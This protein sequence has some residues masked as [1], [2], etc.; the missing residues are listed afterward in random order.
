MTTTSTPP[1]SQPGPP[2]S[3]GPTAE[4]D[5]WHRP[6]ADEDPERPPDFGDYITHRLPALLRFAYAVTGNPH[7]ADEVVQEVLERVGVR[8][9]SIVRKGNPDAY[10]RRA[11]VNARTSRWRRRR[12][13][14]LVAELPEVGVHTRDRFDDEPLWQ[15]LRT[16]A[17]GQR[18]VIVL[19]YYEGMDEAQIAATLGISTG[20]V[21]SQTSRAMTT[22]RRHLGSDR[23]GTGGD[24]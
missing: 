17:P 18:A 3:S 6:G 15:A 13:E 1:G 11:I 5:R 12:S 16:L 19:R 8:W 7:D 21:K 24:R 2:A 4:S 10:I 23:P 9:S 22:L 20:T 14:T